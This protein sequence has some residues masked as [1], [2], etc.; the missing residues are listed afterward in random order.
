MRDSLHELPVRL[1]ALLTLATYHSVAGSSIPDI[2]LTSLLSPPILQQK[3]SVNAVAIG[4]PSVGA[5]L[6]AGAPS[7]SA[8]AESVVFKVH[9]YPCPSDSFL[10]AEIDEGLIKEQVSELWPLLVHVNSWSLNSEP[11]WLGWA[12]SEHEKILSRTRLAR[13]CKQ[14]TLRGLNIDGHEECRCKCRSARRIQL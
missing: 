8:A 14:G 10:D 2:V 3:L 5:E 6:L 9:D 1:V 12:A 7:Q 11:R 4:A 13:S